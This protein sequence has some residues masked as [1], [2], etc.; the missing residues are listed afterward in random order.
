MVIVCG[1]LPFWAGAQNL[2]TTS[3]GD[4]TSIDEDR[5]ISTRFTTL[6]HFQQYPDSLISIDTNVHFFHQ[7]NPVYQHDRS[8]EQLGNIG[9]PMFSLEW[10]PFL[11]T[12]FRPGLR[13]FDELRMTSD[14]IRFYN[15]YTPH[16][17]LNYVQGA[18]EL[19]WLKGLYTRNITPHWNIGGRFDRL[20]SNGAYLNQATNHFNAAVN[21]RFSTP[22]GRYQAF[23]SFVYNKFGQG[24]NGGMNNYRE[25]INE[26]DVNRTRLSVKN[27]N[28]SQKWKDREIDLTHFLFIGPKQ[29]DTAYKESD[30]F[31]DKS[32]R[33]N[34]YLRHKINHYKQSVAYKD[35]QVNSASEDFYPGNYYESNQQT[36]DSLFWT[37]ISTE[38]AISN[39]ALNADTTQP[40]KHKPKFEA[41][42]SIES[43]RYFQGGNKTDS[44]SYDNQHNLTYN[45]LTVFGK[46][47]LPFYNNQLELEGEFLPIGIFQG[48]FKTKEALKIRLDSLKTLILGHKS[49]RQHPDYLKSTMFSNH[50]R[51]QA[52]WNPA[53]VNKIFAGLNH[54]G[55]N[56]E[57]K[58]SY[59]LMHEYMYFDEKIQPRQTSIPVSAI[60]IEADHTVKLVNNV[61]LAN[62]LV[63]QETPND[64][65]L[66]LP[67]WHIRSSLYYKNK[68]FEDQLLLQT[69]FDFRYTDQY[70][71]E[72][73][74]PV[75][76]LRHLQR[77]QL[78][79]GFPV[80]D[81]YLNFRIKR[82]RGFLKFA[83]A[84]Q[85]LNSHDY[86][87]SPRYPYMP[88][89]FTFGVDW[90]FFD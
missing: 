27:E 35:P 11:E 37:N 67:E 18:N 75:Y 41:G 9:T 12:G 2:D 87:T 50:L 62:H 48:D 32:V 77:Q 79:Q 84:N 64:D 23:A 22:S 89:M 7:Y 6:P 88:R 15:T 86:F 40:H 47:E 55:M 90:M 74:F 53:F 46:L 3:L 54:K 82:F 45:N 29:E 85:G 60:S 13:H 73:Y 5:R 1:W 52:H 25:F 69:G 70:Y 43:G 10:E 42:A 51:W 56:L 20:T 83:H 44:T 63:L 30:T 31:V 14:N 28:L 76:S 66:R 4:T 58:V 21:S 57:G 16:T 59:T 71:G 68:L 78:V 34:L 72:R 36:H 24:E 38:F 33:S 39:F 8:L 26:E 17:K 65:I 61:E 81:F 19:Q 80:V 49:Q